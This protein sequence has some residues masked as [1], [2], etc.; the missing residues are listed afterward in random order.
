MLHEHAVDHRPDHREDELF[1]PRSRS[2]LP[3]GACARDHELH[4][5]FG[6][7]A[8]AARGERRYGRLQRRRERGSEERETRREL[9]HRANARK[10]ER[11]VSSKAPCVREAHLHLIDETTE[12]GSDER[13]LGGPTSID[14][15][16]VDL[17]AKSDALDAERLD[18]A[19]RNL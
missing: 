9:D 8:Y 1:D 3:S 2:P 13:L 18:A 4:G 14:A 11:E 7:G 16:L 5:M 15:R 12:R 6:G 19:L 10:D 17:G